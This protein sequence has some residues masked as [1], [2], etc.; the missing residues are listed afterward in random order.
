MP[1]SEN[2]VYVNRR[3]FRRTVRGWLIIGGAGVAGALLVHALGSTISDLTR[4][5]LAALVVRGAAFFL[6]GLAIGRTFFASVWAPRVAF[7]VG[8][9]AGYSL[10]LLWPNGSNLWPVAVVLVTV[11]AGI[12]TLLGCLS[13]SMLRRRAGAL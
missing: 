5:G 7:S 3:Q 1:L 8:V 11:T 6:L 9:C 4:G 10:A 13:G 2:E 12:P